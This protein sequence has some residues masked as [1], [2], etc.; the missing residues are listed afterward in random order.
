MRIDD[1]GPS[2]GTDT[3]LV[4]VVFEI[5][6]KIIPFS[7]SENVTD[8]NVDYVNVKMFFSVKIFLRIQ[9]FCSRSN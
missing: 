1:P 8:E 6:S 2:L 7:I 4:D 3:T 9:L 5:S